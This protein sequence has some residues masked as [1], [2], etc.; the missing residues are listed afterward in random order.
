MLIG[1]RCGI[2]GA[3]IGNVALAVAEGGVVLVHGEAERFVEAKRSALI[4]R[5][6]NGALLAGRMAR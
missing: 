4:D 6:D 5:G 1:A 2:K 3:L